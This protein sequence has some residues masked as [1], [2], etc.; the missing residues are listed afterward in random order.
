MF[1]TQLIAVKDGFYPLTIKAFQNNLINGLVN[2]LLYL[3]R[4]LD[5]NVL[6]PDGEVG[7]PGV[8]LVARDRAE[9]AAVA[10]LYQSLIERSAGTSSEQLRRHLKS[11]RELEVSD[12]REE[13]ADGDGG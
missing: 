8:V 13:E 11:E 2:N 5:V 1:E 6:Q 4:V 3:V 9:V 7:V 10:R 12:V